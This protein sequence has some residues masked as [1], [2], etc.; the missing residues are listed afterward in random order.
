[1][2]NL[3]ATRHATSSAAASRTSSPGF[4]SWLTGERASSLPP[5][6]VPLEGVSLPP[7][8]PDFVEPGKV[9]SKILENGVTI[10]SEASLVCS[11]RF[12]L[13]MLFCPKFL[14]FSKLLF[15]G[16]FFLIIKEV[17]LVG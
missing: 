15:L 3:G 5:L 2:G 13:Y 17:Y 6:E 7:S 1:M 4:F 12:S 10:V 16:V 11:Y 9:Q 14:P 8:L